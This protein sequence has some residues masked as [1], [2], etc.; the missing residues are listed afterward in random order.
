MYLFFIKVVNDHFS[1][2]EIFIGYNEDS[3]PGVI[4]SAWEISAEKRNAAAEDV[5]FMEVLFILLR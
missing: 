4:L 5:T 1:P 3:C 2:A